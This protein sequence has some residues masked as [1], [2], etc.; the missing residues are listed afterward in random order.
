MSRT[1]HKRQFSVKLTLDAIFVS[2]IMCLIMTITT[3][4]EDFTYDD[5]TKRLAVPNIPQVLSTTT[6]DLQVTTGQAL[7]TVPVGKVL[8]I[9]QIVCRAFTANLDKSFNYG[10]NA[11]DFNNARDWTTYEASVVPSTVGYNLL[12]IPNNFIGGTTGQTTVALGIGRHAEGN[13]GDVL[14]LKMESANTN[15]GTMK[16]DVIGY[17]VDA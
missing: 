9:I 17:L 1:A 13:A 11:S 14:T 15:A 8:V 3:F 2:G 12:A 4:A 6:I 10:Y 7:Y 16:V 5:V